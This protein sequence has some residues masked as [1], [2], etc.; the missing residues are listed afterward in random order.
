MMIKV[1]IT[2]RV[3][4]SNHVKNEEFETM[5][6]QNTYTKCTMMNARKEVAEAWR[7]SMFPGA[8]EV[9]IMGIRKIQLSNIQSILFNLKI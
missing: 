5:V 1:K 2:V 3:K 7:N 4:R 6:D 8:D 9:M